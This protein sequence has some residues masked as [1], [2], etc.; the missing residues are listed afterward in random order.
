MVA[1]CCAFCGK[2]DAPEA[3]GEAQG[4]AHG[5]RGFF[6]AQNGAIGICRHCARA[7]VRWFGEIPDTSPNVVA[8]RPIGPKAGPAEEPR[9]G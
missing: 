2:S 5:G 6:A 4:E 7:A 1:W 3:H 9:G 8:L